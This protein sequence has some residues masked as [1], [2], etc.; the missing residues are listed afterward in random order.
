MDAIGRTILDFEY[1]DG[2]RTITD[3]GG[4]SLTIIDPTDKAL[5]VSD[6]G[7]VAHWKLDDG[8]GMTATDS[9]GTN[10]GTLNGDPTWITGRIG[11]AL[12]FDGSGDYISVAPIAAL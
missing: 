2:W 5:S 4:F 1:R 8:I 10:N 11:G 7:L 9:A 12:D 6:L 3:G